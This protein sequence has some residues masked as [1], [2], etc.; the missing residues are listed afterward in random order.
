MDVLKCILKEHDMG[1]GHKPEIS[2]KERLQWL[3][4]LE[5]GQ[6]ITSI[7]K[8]AG[9]DI[10]IVK[11]NID[12]AREE[13]QTA[14]VRQDFLLGKLELHQQDLLCEV[15]RLKDLLKCFP[16][17][18]VVLDEALQRKVHEA[19]LEHINRLA[20]KGLF[21]SWD[22]LSQEFGT[23]LDTV[24]S[25]ISMKEN[26]IK[27][28][29]PKLQTLDWSASIFEALETEP[30]PGGTI[31]MK[32]KHYEYSRVN[33][34]YHPY[35]GATMLTPNPLGKADANLVIKAHQ[36]LVEYSSKYLPSFDQWRG[37]FKE[38]SEQIVDELDVFIVKRMVPSK[39]R[40][41]PI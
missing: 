14:R 32:L 9:R 15:R 37:R 22:T 20:L 19:L 2:P 7:C 4:K 24:K 10:R 16:P 33:E 6:G 23:M 8:E 3:E 27:F 25:E 29:I 12:L 18:G 40:Y 30:T 1:R 11:R 5:D 17:Q 41:C 21:N 36:E 13:R 28:A 38:L 26:E 31:F 34:Q 35:W 39:C